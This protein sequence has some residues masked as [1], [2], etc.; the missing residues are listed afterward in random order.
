M[1]LLLLTINCPMN[2]EFS[3][4]FVKDCGGCSG[5]SLDSLDGSYEVDPKVKQRVIIFDMRGRENY[6][7]EEHNDLA[8]LADLLTKFNPENVEVYL[9]APSLLDAQEHY[10]IEV[11]AQRLHV[12]LAEKMARRNDIRDS[13]K[14]YAAGI[15]GD[16]KDVKFSMKKKFDKKMCIELQVNQMTKNFDT[17]DGLCKFIVEVGKGFQVRKD[18]I[19][20]FKRNMLKDGVVATPRV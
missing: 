13:F 16:F 6:F 15:D 3:G 11:F 7:N 9:L 17:T 19:S 2:R 14:Y 20:M 18:T 4:F 1:K 12:T 10:T 5:M 8:P